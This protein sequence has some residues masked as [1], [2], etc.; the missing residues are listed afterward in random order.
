M[1]ALTAV[2]SSAPL[3][4]AATPIAATGANQDII[5]EGYDVGGDPSQFVTSSFD[6]PNGSTF[7][8]KGIGF[9]GDPGL[10]ESFSS[11]ADPTVSFE[12]LGSFTENNA[13][14]LMNGTSGSLVITSPAAYTSIFV[15]SASANGTGTGTATIHFAGGSSVPLA[16]TSGDWYSSTDIA[17][18]GG[19]VY[20]SISGGALGYFTNGSGAALPPPA[21][22]QYELDIPEA[23]EDLEVTSIDFAMDS[24]GDDRLS[25]A[26]MGLSGNVTVPEPSVALLFS[27]LGLL[28]LARR[29]R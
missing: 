2:L 12:L 15:L 3:L 1:A 9:G 17:I 16:F 10:L 19:P 8:A 21:L 11:A 24:V 7:L 28:G 27:G 5:V 18:G 4:H 14:Q 23:Y 29:R 20:A 6:I 13:L 22:F 26:I 25:T